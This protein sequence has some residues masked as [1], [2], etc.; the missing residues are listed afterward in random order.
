MEANKAIVERALAVIRAL[1][2]SE[3]RPAPEALPEVRPMTEATAL[4]E[5]PAVCSQ[6]SRW[7]EPGA[8][9]W[10]C[11][12]RKR[13]ACII[14]DAGAALEPRPGP[15]AVCHGDGKLPERVQ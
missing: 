7:W 2:R 12:G 9:C 3:P 14:C 15:C 5:K 8:V 10:H 1:N 11:K 4:A 6:F 13:C